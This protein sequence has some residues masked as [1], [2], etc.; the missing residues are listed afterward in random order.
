M[1]NLFN[2][3]GFGS[4]SQA[5]PDPS[6]AAIAQDP[7]DEL[8]GCSLFFYFALF[9]VLFDNLENNVTEFLRFSPLLFFFSYD[10]FFSSSR[11]PL[12][13]CVCFTRLLLSL[14]TYWFIFHGLKSDVSAKVRLKLQIKVSTGDGDNLPKHRGSIGSLATIAIEEGN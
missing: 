2:R 12:H 11:F 14:V 10:L 13:L 5:Q 3:L 9:R 4:H 6:S 1:N 7:S 8:L